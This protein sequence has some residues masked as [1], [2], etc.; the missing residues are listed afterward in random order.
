MNW[1]Q[2]RQLPEEEKK[3]DVYYVVGLDLGDD[4][5]CIAYYNLAIDEA[6]VIDLSGGYGRT[7][8]PTVVQYVAENREWVF[9]E[10]AVQNMESGR[11]FTV[12][13]LIGRLGNSEYLDIDGK[14][15][16][17]VNVLGLY[18]KELM[19]NVKNINPKAE[20]AG[21]VVA[22]PPYFSD[23]AKKEMKR[24]FKYAGF[25]KELIDL[26]ADRECVFSQFYKENPKI[27]HTTLMI[28]YG[29]REARAG[30]Y[31][32][33]EEKIR[34]LSSLFEDIGTREI[35]AGARALFTAYYKANSVIAPDATTQNQLAI[36]THQHKDI[37]FQKSI[38]AKASKLYFNFAFPPF[39]VTVTKED[40]LGLTEPF[41]RRF[42][43][44]IRQVFEK[45]SQKVSLA[46]IDAVICVGGGFEMYWTRE[47]VESLFPQNK[48]RMYKNS[49]GV[50][51]MGAATTA[52]QLLGV[53]ERKHIEV[54][55]QHQ[56]D[57]D[58]VVMA[59]EN[60]VP[61]AE[62]NTFWWRT[63][64]TKIFVINEVVA[65]DVPFQILSKTSAG[66]TVVLSEV[67]LTG[68]PERPKGTTRISVNLKFV[69]EKVATAVVSDMGF[70]ELF[71]KSGYRQEIGVLL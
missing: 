57:V 49:K 36:F 15:V 3:Q 31:R 23:R 58:I 61:L 43:K 24:A 10:Y 63:H 1:K 7:S 30:I 47:A 60:F 16:S 70:G 28:D 65:G 6:E 12:N 48:L 13:G 68:L 37:L 17:I 62:C 46:D 29:A 54:E 55:D 44:F 42:D 11:E 45:T 9:G 4:S 25:E 51:A 35:E 56:L 21:I 2:Y 27:G 52:A 32:L 67:P 39:Q 38:R 40:A 69:S 34:S 19:G 20:I 41:H 18:I 33:E 71:P 22:V 50:T 8:M 5:S 53:A 26:V 64:P 66:E 14:P 59:G